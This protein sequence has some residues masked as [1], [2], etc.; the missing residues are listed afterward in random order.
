VGIPGV[1]HV[2]AVASGK[3]GVGKSTTAVNLAVALAQRLG[4]RVGL[5]DADVYG[6]SIPRMMRLAG[7]PRVDEGTGYLLRAL[8]V[9]SA[10]RNEAPGRERNPVMAAQSLRLG[11]HRLHGP[12]PSGPP[13]PT[14][15]PA[16]ERML[17]LVNH[18]VACMSMGFLMKEDVAAVWRGPMV[19]GA[20]AGRT[21][22]GSV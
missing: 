11:A 12:P 4:L 20:A 17:P 1:D 13:P 16:D 8:G 15:A 5:L 6:P 7:K 21:A 18:G 10:R 2:I 19:G 14:L 3:G 9:G 22:C